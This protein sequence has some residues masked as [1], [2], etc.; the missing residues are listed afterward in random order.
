MSIYQPNNEVRELKDL[1]V[2]IAGTKQKMKLIIDFDG[3]GKFSY[4]SELSK[5]AT[6][7]FVLNK[8]KKA[9]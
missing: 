2:N 5:D 9:D 7:F 6:K 4:R 8:T 3:S 1:V